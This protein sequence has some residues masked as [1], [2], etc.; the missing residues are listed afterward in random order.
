[1]NQVHSLVLPSQCEQVFYSEVPS[2]VGWSYIVRY[3]PRGRPV[4]YNV[5]EEEGDADQEQLHINIDV[6]DE[7]SDQ[8]VDHPNDVEEYDIDGE[9]LTK[10]D[11]DHYPNTSDLFNDSD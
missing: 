1:M 2:K 8:E 11:F 4:K 3:N 9:Y 7:E 5:V 10:T 6:L